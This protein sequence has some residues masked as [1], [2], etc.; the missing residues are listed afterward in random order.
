MDLPYPISTV[1]HH[2]WM[3]LGKAPEINIDASVPVHFSETCSGKSIKLY[4]R[5]W[6]KVLL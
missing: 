5:V 2:P 4:D 3:A 1:M 6:T